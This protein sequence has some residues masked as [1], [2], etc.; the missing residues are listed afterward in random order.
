MVL[1][2]LLFALDAFGWITCLF[3]FCISLSLAPTLFPRISRCLVWIDPAIYKQVFCLGE[4]CEE[5]TV[6]AWDVWGADIH[7]VRH[8][9]QNILSMQRAKRSCLE[10]SWCVIHEADLKEK[11][12]PDLGFLSVLCL[13]WQLFVMPLPV[14]LSTAVGYFGRG[15]FLANL[16]LM[17]DQKDPFAFLTQC[18]V[19]GKS[20][21]QRQAPLLK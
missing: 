4:T 1:S 8:R 10:W 5:N 9:L 17:A 20:V 16:A 11:Y 15:S 13:H 19:L 2:F 18:L 14:G 7:T 6:V 3:S 21:G 12:L